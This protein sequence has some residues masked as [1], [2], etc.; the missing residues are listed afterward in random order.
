MVRATNLLLM[1]L[2]Y[3]D[4]VSQKHTLLGVFTG[5]RASRFPSPARDM[6]AY[7]LLE[8]QPGESGILA[9][10]LQEEETPTPSHLAEGLVTIGQGGKRHV[11]IRLSKVRF[12][13]AGRYQFT[14]LFDDT[15][16]AN[17]TIT[18]RE[19]QS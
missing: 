8:G 14:L 6:S 16:I 1:D 11:H 15:P 19:V 4:P 7:A 18:V 2:V 12:P 3:E 17:Q 13:R 9:L 10:Q 5:L